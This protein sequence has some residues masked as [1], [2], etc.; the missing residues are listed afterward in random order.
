MT[1][2]PA[3]CFNSNDGAANVQGANPLFSYTWETTSGVVIASGISYNNF[4][5]GDYLLVAHYY[6]SLNSGLVYSGCDV[7]A[8]FTI[9]SPSEIQTNATNPVAVSCYGDTDG[10]INLQIV[11][12]TG[13]YTVQWD[14]TTSLPNGS[15]ATL[16]DNLQ[17]GTYTANIVDSDGCM[18]TNDFVIGEPDALTNNFTI[19]Q[20]LCSGLNG[21]LS[22]NTQGGTGTYS[23]APPIA[24]GFAA[25]SVTFT[26][27]D[28]NG[29]STQDIAVF[30]DPDPIV[31]S[32]EPD[33]LYFGP[34]DV[35]CNGASDGS[36]TVVSGGG[37]SIISYSWSPGGSNAAT[38]NN[39][40]AGTYTV[41]VEDDNGC[42]EQQT[43]TI[44]EPDVLVAVVSKSGDSAPFDISCYDY[45]DGW[46][47]SDPTGGVA[48]TS[49]YNF[50]W[51]LSGSSFSTNY[52][53]ENLAAGNNYTVTVTDANGCV[54]SES[55]GLLT[56][57]VDFIAD[58]G[59]NYIDPLNSPATVIFNDNTISSDP[60][61]F[62]WNWE[63]GNTEF[64]SSG[65]ST[66]NLDFTD[67]FGM[68]DIYVSLENEL[69]GCI[70]SVGFKIEVQGIP[71]INNV[72]T[73]NGDN[74]NDFFSF[75]EYAMQEITVEIFNRWGQIVYSWNTPSYEWDGRDYDGR[76]LAEGVYYYVLSSQGLDGEL[77]SEKGSITLLR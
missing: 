51:Q 30:I 4:Y 7:S 55:T 46:A 48:A 15:N 8:A 45:S 61:N 63:D 38:A 16:I 12:G 35:S 26:I 36:A 3:S 2:N 28:Q 23:Y 56:E 14:T 64:Y 29:C 24:G 39:L 49:G 25:G 21:T 59:S 18:I 11:G 70:D 75:S 5:P 73:P 47:Q 54:V 27:T 57:P 76:N 22:A 71:E 32:L 37:T 40:S 33:N 6:D 34:Y 62:T 10:E 50:N 9:S 31:S 65:T 66:F 17:P 1:T 67:K 58:V 44:T 42:D 69:T 53:V 41:T 77:Y 60:Y 19:N 13:F 43:I 74:V 68:N 52:Y 20:P 72:F